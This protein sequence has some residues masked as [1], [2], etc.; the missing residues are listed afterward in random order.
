[1]E[2]LFSSHMAEKKC[3]KTLAIFLR[4]TNSKHNA[5]E[6]GVLWRCWCANNITGQHSSWLRRST[7]SCLLSSF[8]LEMTANIRCLK[9]EWGWLW[10]HKR[11]QNHGDV[12]AFVSL[13]RAA[14]ITGWKPS[15][16]CLQEWVNWG[17]M[18]N[19]AHLQIPVALTFLS[20]QQALTAHREGRAEWVGLLSSYHV[21][22]QCIHDEDFGW[23]TGWANGTLKI[24]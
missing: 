22:I 10:S 13:H 3:I 19:Q 15:A 11:M 20:T 14:N 17:T 6:K 4:S 24:L 9:I 8:T 5:K 16:M 7:P 18:S 23:Q 2:K 21:C 1:M 12:C